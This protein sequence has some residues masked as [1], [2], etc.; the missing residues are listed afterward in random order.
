M[1]A[2]LRRRVA[3]F[4]P[5]EKVY[6]RDSDV[7]ITGLPRDWRRVLSMSHPC[8]LTG[9]FG[10]V[11]AD[12][13]HALIAFRILH[14]TN[15]PALVQLFRPNYLPFATARSCRR[16]GSNNGLSLLMSQPDDRYWCIVRDRCM[17]DIVYQRVCRDE[18]YR[19]VLRRLRE[20]GLLPVYHVRT[21]DKSTYWG[22]IMDK[23][24]L[25]L[26]VDRG[27]RTP[28]VDALAV[29]QGGR[30]SCV[31]PSSI[32]IG[33]NRLGQIMVEAMET[34]VRVHERGCHIRGGSALKLTSDRI[35]MT[36]ISP[37]PDEPVPSFETLSPRS[38]AASS[39]PPSFFPDAHR[40]PAKD[41]LHEKPK[42]PGNGE[43]GTVHEAKGKRKAVEDNFE[44]G[45]GGVA[46]GKKA[47]NVATDAPSDEDCEDSEKHDV[48]T[49]YSASCPSSTVYANID[50]FIDSLL[51]DEECDDVFFTPQTTVPT[52]PVSPEQPS[53]PHSCPPVPTNFTII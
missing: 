18:V 48:F 36:P 2:D 10:N 50:S 37:L 24:K 7:E 27:N 14:T 51:P 20:E 41:A 32:L 53:R 17:F 5:R 40:R 31:D 6:R 11:Y 23:T 16:Y 12:M 44:Y 30:A 49:D 22:G 46:H 33:G 34:Y 45:D 26:S 29:E 28:D 21:A 35:P 52:P 9:P 13:E 8:R 4:G 3:Y 1:S 25:T 19:N 39:V 15:N 42:E 47:R 38:F 43:R